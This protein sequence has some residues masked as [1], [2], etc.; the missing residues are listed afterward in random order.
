MHMEHM[1][2]MV[3]SVCGSYSTTA[4]RAQMGDACTGAQLVVIG[5]RSDLHDAM[6][7]IQHPES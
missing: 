4:E 2:L 3:Q 6:L 7:V 5:G 1:F